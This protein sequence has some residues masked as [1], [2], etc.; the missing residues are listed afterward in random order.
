MRPD[1][2]TQRRF[3]LGF[4]A[5][6]WGE[7]AGECFWQMKKSTNGDGPVGGDNV[8]ADFDGDGLDV[9]AI[10]TGGAANGKDRVI[11]RLG[12]K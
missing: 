5:C 4:L 8:V 1:S 11:V 2:T 10:H 12:A 9:A 6:E 3:L 7:Q